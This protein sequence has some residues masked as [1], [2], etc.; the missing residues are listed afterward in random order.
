MRRGEADALNALERVHLF[1][2]LYE[3]R[4]ATGVDV[5][6]AAVARDDL[7]EERDLLHAAG[8][9]GAALGHDV[10][11]RPRALVAAGF[12]HDAERAVHVAALLDGNE[13]ADLVLGEFVVADGVLRAGLLGQVHD[14][15]AEGHAGVPGGPEIVE[16]VRDLVEFLGAD[17]QVH[18]GQLV[19]Q[20]DPAVLRHAAEDPEDEV[21]VFLLPREDV[22][23]LA[24]GLLLGGVPDRA[25]VEQE[26]VAV[27]LRPDNPVTPGA[28]HRRDSFAVALVHLAPVSLEVDAVHGGSGSA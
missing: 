17:D 13:G 2:Q 23:G 10:V 28:Q 4:D 1:Q 24:D 3:R 12:G 18:V 16:V 25:G 7:A 5:I 14:G 20:R 22:A 6:T 15:L 11:H 8:G 27:V 26:D 21:G 19:E 9:E